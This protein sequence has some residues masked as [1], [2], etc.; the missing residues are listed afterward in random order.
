[1]EQR[2][3]FRKTAGEPRES[4]R[5]GFRVTLGIIPDYGEEVEGVRL[6]GVR[7]GS[8][9]DKCGLRSGD[10]MVGWSGK[11]ITNIYDLTYLLQEHRPGDR[12]E[13]SVVRDGGE[14]SFTATLE[15]R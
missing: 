7:E 12:V 9:A 11:K 6:T 14:M 2:L 4:G 5:S 13:I 10:L 15:G 3:A 1:M 8:P